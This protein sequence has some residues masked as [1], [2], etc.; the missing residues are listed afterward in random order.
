MGRSPVVT[1]AGDS[2]YIGRGPRS[3]ADEEYAP[4]S[5]PM[6]NHSRG[7]TQVN[8]RTVIPSSIYLVNK[9][10]LIPCWVPGI[11]LCCLS[12][13]WGCSNRSAINRWLVDNRNL[14]LMVQE[15]GSPR[16]RH[17]LIRC[18]VRFYC[19]VHRQLPSPCVLT[20]EE[21]QG[22]FLGSLL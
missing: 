16:S 6:C 8:P 2:P 4:Q 7:G 19:L 10:I 22:S 1:G 11:V 21:G 13:F 18:V 15:A 14:F 12:W 17:Q 20:R 9:Y 3:R 5:A